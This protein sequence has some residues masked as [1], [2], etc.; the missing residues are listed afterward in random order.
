M[1]AAQTYQSEFTGAQMD[2]RFTAVATLTAALE[3]LTAVVAGKYVKPADGIPSSD[4]TAA[5]QASLAKAETAVQS[6]A[7]YYTKTE[8]DQLLAAINGMDYVDVST[9]P[10]ASASTMGKI[11]LLG[12]DASGYYSYYY[13]SYNGSAYSWVGPLGTTEIS[14]SNYATK[15]EVFTDQTIRT[16]TSV[17]KIDG[18]T[19]KNDYSASASASAISFTALNGYDSYY[20]Y[21]TKGCKAWLG[22]SDAAYLSI[23][24]I[25]SAQPFNNN[26]IAGTNGVRKRK[27]E[28]NLPT[29]QAPLT[30][31]AGMAVVITITEGK[32][33]DFVSETTEET[34]NGATPLAPEHIA[35]VR[36][37]IGS[38][39]VAYDATATGTITESV[40][41]YI[42][43]KC[44]YIDFWFGHTVD[45]TKNANIWG[46]AYARAAAEDYTPIRWLTTGGNWE[47][48]IALDTYNNFAGGAQHGNEQLT[49][50]VF[51]ADGL[52]FDPSTLASPLA[53]D[54]LR[55]IMVSQIY[56]PSAPSNAFAKHTVEY[57]WTRD[58]LRIEQAVVFLSAC[59]VA[60]SYL[61][62]FPVMQ[63]VT[64][65]YC[66]DADFAPVTIPSGGVPSTTIDNATVINIWSATAAFFAKFAIERNM[67]FVSPSRALI[68]N[69]GQTTY[70]KCYF[71]TNI[72]AVEVENGDVWQS[73]TVYQIEAG[74]V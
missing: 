24:T 23:C 74:T 61:A 3:E 37:S 13:T 46:M 54:E 29:A 63:S 26:S 20:F 11:Y 31:S 21:L 34:F 66:T 41:V 8:V 72:D 19:K 5:V 42:P 55:V 73:T 28:G 59:N 43:A 18:V 68:T 48:A 69:N 32:L 50:I 51:L 10:T 65:R 36:K 16:S 33:V 40:H 71:Y 70:N 49:S 6:L 15:T 45:A 53:F 4:M 14:L 12:P 58:G 57:V 44:G 38:P 56:D 27:S 62:M 67:S 60:R 2:A 17:E 7:D 52:T 9:L 39:M 1:A 47:A 30:L 22:T 64:D 25:E 35:Q